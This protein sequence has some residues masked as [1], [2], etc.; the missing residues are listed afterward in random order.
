MSAFLQIEKPRQPDLAKHDSSIL[1]KFYLKLFQLFF[2]IC[3]DLVF[4]MDCT[5]SMGLYIDSAMDNIRA[6][7]EEIIVTE[8]S[9]IR[10]ALVEYRDHK[11]QVNL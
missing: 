6:I 11:P 3:S 9:D 7:I 10:L 4:A 1:G 8:K 5:S 2:H